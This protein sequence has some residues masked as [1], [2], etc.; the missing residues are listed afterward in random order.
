M[1]AVVSV[2]QKQ[3]EV[4]TNQNVFWAQR[5]NSIQCRGSVGMWLSEMSCDSVDLEQIFQDLVKGNKKRSR[6]NNVP[7]I[8]LNNHNPNNNIER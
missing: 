3:H 6:S 2:C 7:K 1:I 5:K 4:R 8:G